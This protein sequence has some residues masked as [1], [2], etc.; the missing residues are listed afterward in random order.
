MA[1]QKKNLAAQEIINDCTAKKNGCAAIF[2]PLCGYSSV[3]CLKNNR[4]IQY[5]HFSFLALEIHVRMA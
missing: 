4:S 3:R 2:A 5:D 1:A